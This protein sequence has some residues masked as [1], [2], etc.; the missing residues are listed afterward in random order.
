MRANNKFCMPLL[1]RY[2]TTGRAF[3]A[4]GG[5][6]KSA[7]PSS[8]GCKPNGNKGALN[9]A[10]YQYRSFSTKDEPG[11]DVQN[12]AV[13]GS[14]GTDVAHTETQP[15]INSDTFVRLL[16]SFQDKNSGLLLAM[17][18]FK[19]QIQVEGERAYPFRIRDL[20]VLL[21]FCSNLL[22]LDN[23]RESTDTLLAA[24]Q[25]FHEDGNSLAAFHLCRLFSSLNNCHGKTMTSSVFQR[26][27]HNNIGFMAAKFMSP[28][29]MGNISQTYKSGAEQALRHIA[30]S[31][32]DGDMFAIE[33][34]CE[35]GLY[36][37]I[38][39]GKSYLDRMGLRIQLEIYDVKHVKL[40]NFLITIGGKRGDE[41]ESP[42]VM[43]QAMAHQILVQVPTNRVKSQGTA[44][45]E[46]APLNRQQSHELVKKSFDN[47]IVARMEVLLTAKQLLSLVD[48]EQNT[49]WQ[50]TKKLCTHKLTFESEV[51]M[52][53]N[54]GEDFETKDWT[55]V[56]MNGVLNSNAPFTN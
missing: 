41:I 56:D 42:Y 40:D 43:K 33:Q 13:G 35:R 1:K 46:A 44:S 3:A 9:S 8:F 15:V 25:L 32:S 12:P 30:S 7:I 14:S 51:Q 45:E 53:S 54:D 18:K 20:R 39:Q 19:D 6:C 37:F 34:C 16:T 36:D 50:D 48:K 5:R 27:V 2:L 24:L 52:K 29:K 26:A 17:Q 4:L 31:L 28:K 10:A 38:Q 47:G 21:E 49:V 23:C 11:K 22:S 55:M